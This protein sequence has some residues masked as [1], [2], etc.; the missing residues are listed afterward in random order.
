MS[1]LDDWTAH[2]LEETDM[3]R[4]DLIQHAQ[5]M[6]HML[7]QFM[8]MVEHDRTSY[9]AKA[10]RIAQ[11]VMQLAEEATKVETERALLVQLGKVER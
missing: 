5:G 10:R 9:A 7:Q 4:Q 1:R 6:E 11:L 2:K 8:E 3:L